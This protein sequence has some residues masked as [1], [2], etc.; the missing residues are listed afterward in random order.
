[1]SRVRAWLDATPLATVAIALMREATGRAEPLEVVRPTRPERL[2]VDARVGL[3]SL[4]AGVGTST[5]AALLAQ[6]SAAGGHAPLLVDADRWA[7]SL[8][9]K[10]RTS[11]ASS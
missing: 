11:E 7:P 2:R 8:A 10:T 1:M 5:T 3:W 4:N 9:L 6:R